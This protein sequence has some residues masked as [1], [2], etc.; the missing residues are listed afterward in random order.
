MMM[1]KAMKVVGVVV[2]EEEEAQDA[3]CSVT[4]HMSLILC[5]M[6]TVKWVFYILNILQCQA[7]P[8]Q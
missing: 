8:A 4:P 5:Y 7:E 1:M 6:H 3:L 2:V